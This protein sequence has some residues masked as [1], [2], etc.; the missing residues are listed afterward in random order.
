MMLTRTLV[1]VAAS[2]LLAVPGSAAAQGSFALDA[3]QASACASVTVTLAASG[4]VNGQGFDFDIGY[5]A[6]VVNVTNVELAGLGAAP[7][8]ACQA[9]VF[10]APL[11][12]QDPL[13]ETLSI[14]VACPGGVSGTGTFLSLT[15]TPVGNGVSPLT[16]SLCDVN[17][18]AC[19]AATAGAVTVTCFPTPTPT[20]VPT[21]TPTPAIPCTCQGDAN[22]NGFVN[23]ADYG[24]VSANFGQA[25]PPAGNGDA[26]CNGFVNFADYGAVS[27]N[28]GQP[29]PAP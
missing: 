2:A 29:C 7:A 16:F 10:N 24:A 8:A 11:D 19:S 18:Q 4:L 1:F 26:N 9:P 6:A 3:V 20:P 12:P 5:D 15:L 21:V 25:N 28:F 22:K 14:A 23:F 13:F 27:A 17:E